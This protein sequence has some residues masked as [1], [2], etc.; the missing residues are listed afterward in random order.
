MKRLLMAFLVTVLLS[1]CAGENSGTYPN[2]SVTSVYQQLA[3][4]KTVVK[5]ASTPTEAQKM[6]VMKLF[7]AM[8]KA[9]PGADLLNLC[10]GWLAG[11]MT[12]VELANLIAGTD[13]FQSTALYPKSMSNVDFAAKFMNNL[14]GSTVSEATKSLVATQLAIMLDNG[15]TRGYAAWVLASALS[16][17]PTSNPDWGKASAQFA[18]KLSVS[19][20]YSV[21][22]AYSATD[23][24]VLQAVTSSVTDDPATVTS[25]KASLGCTTSNP[26]FSVTDMVGTWD[27][28]LDMYADP[29]NSC[30]ALPT[31]QQHMTCT[32]TYAA[33]CTI[34]QVCTMTFNGYSYT[35]PPTTSKCNP[36]DVTAPVV[37]DPC[38]TQYS[39]VTNSTSPLSFTFTGTVN[40][41]VIAKITQTKRN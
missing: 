24:T 8:F 17:I 1:A 34:T 9:A 25:A 33:D 37:T 12:E 39:T 2:S 32:L 10:S 14:V 41:S 27:T 29:N 38:N 16:D 20:C 4:Q 11:G 40:G 35:T 31:V 19:Y 28:V 30:K 23:L 22:K 13:V 7:Q 5:A 6:V 3:A 15:W 36:N 18:N 21:T 26:T